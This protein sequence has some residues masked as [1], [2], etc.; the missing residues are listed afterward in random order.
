MNKLFHSNKI[1]VRD[2]SKHGRGVFAKEDIK[3]GEMLE[4]CHYIVVDDGNTHDMPIY[5]W[6][7]LRSS[8]K[9][10]RLHQFGWPKGDDFEKHTIALGFGSIYNSGIDEEERSVNWES[11]L[12]KD[13]YRFFTIKDVKKNEE[14]LLYYH[15]GKFN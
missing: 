10:I 3:S 7:R 8:N 15:K 4:E 9:E 2:S 11:D 13:V 1:E 5:K 6:R 14:L 12:D